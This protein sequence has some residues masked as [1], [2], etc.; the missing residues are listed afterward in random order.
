MITNK[1]TTSTTMCFGERN[2]NDDDNNDDRNHDDERTERGINSPLPKPPISLPDILP[3]VMVVMTRTSAHHII[4]IIKQCI[5]K[6]LAM[7][8]YTSE[9]QTSLVHRHTGSPLG[10]F[11]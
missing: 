8:P 6:S 10:K 9:P 4:T 11:I 7:Q 5:K 2:D 1:T 3:N